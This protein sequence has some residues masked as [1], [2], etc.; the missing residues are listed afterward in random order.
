MTDTLGMAL[1]SIA[2]TTDPEMFMV[3]GGVARAGD[4]LFNPPA[5]ALQDL[6][7][8]FLPRDPHRCRYPRQ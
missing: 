2:S 3:G 1:A 4:V 8:Q 6:C 7:L 5:G